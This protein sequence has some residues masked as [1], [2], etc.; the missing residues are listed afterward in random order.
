MFAA[1]SWC[2][3][4]MPVSSTATTT[5]WLPREMSHASYAR[6]LSRPHWLDMSGSSGVSSTCAFRSGETLRTPG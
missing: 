5:S 6:M 3:Q 4:S 2:S 1:R